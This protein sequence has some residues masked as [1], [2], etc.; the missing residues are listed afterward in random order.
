[1]VPSTV[2]FH[3]AALVANQEAGGG[4]RRVTVEVG[5]TVAETYTSPGQYVEVRAD[6]QTGFFVL[7]NE[8]GADKWDFVMRAGGGASDVLMTALPGARIDVTSALGGG[9][10]LEEA[11]G[12]SLIIALS[13]TG[14]AAGPP[15][16]G[17][18]IREGDASRTSVLVGVRT[19]GELPMRPHLEAWRRAGVDVL[20]CLSND[21]GRVEG[22]PYA[23]GYVQDVLR[24][25][26]LGGRVIPGRI[27][28]VGLRSMVDALKILAPELGIAS[29]RVHTNH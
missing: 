10:P 15:I 23:N 12:D 20:V 2:R 5:L 4:L 21:D 1:M 13:G 29:E 8:P 14:I 25:R 18:R 26:V 19:H 16:V 22:I 3:P 7:A 17:R 6:H 11:R 28:A 9:F 27:F 24:A